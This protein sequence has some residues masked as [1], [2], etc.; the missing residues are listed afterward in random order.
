MDNKP[1][2][3]RNNG[4]MAHLILATPESW[5]R[6]N[7]HGSTGQSSGSP[8]ESITFLRPPEKFNELVAEH[9]AAQMKSE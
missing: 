3:G 4:E 6:R 2:T 7:L 9:Q 8:V 1:Q 5:R